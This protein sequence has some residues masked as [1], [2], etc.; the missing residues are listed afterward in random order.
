M[1][2]EEVFSFL[3]FIHHHQQSNENIFL[4]IMKRF[5]VAFARLSL[6]LVKLKRQRRRKKIHFPSHIKAKRLEW[7]IAMKTEHMSNE[8]Y[9]INSISP[10]LAALSPLLH[11]GLNFIFILRWIHFA[12]D[13]QKDFS[14]FNIF[15]I[16][17]HS[18][19]NLNV[20][21]IAMNN[22]SEFKSAVW[23]CMIA[24]KCEPPQRDEGWSFLFA[25]RE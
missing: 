16:T 19:H 3:I 24:G 12:R 10:S 11:R 21:I 18:K 2:V 6:E 13:T 1:A 4:N 9:C 15:I 25:V 5:F 17:K 14:S 23:E 22:E 8:W 20:S 7:K